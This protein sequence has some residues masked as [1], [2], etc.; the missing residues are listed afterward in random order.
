M[1]QAMSTESSNADAFQGNDNTASNNVNAFPIT[2]I[3]STPPTP[4]A[5]VWETVEDYDWSAQATSTVLT[6]AGTATMGGKSI[7]NVT[8]SSTPTYTTQNVNGSGLVWDV[9]AG[10]AAGGGAVFRF[11]LIPADYNPGEQV[12]LEMLI[13]G[14]TWDFANANFF[15][16]IGA[17]GHY[18][19]VE[20]HG[21]QMQAVAGLTTVNHIARGFS[22]SGGARSVTIAAAQPISTNYLVQIWYDGTFCSRV[23]VVEGQTTFLSQPVVGAAAPFNAALDTGHTGCSTAAPQADLL[24]VFA[25]TLRCICGGGTEE[26]GFTLKR[27][28]I[29]RPTRM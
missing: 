14:A 21:L 10:F 1:E 18:S 13:T 6:G 24:G 19:Q 29:S 2:I 26:G 8:V 15:W 27:H 16:G 4:S 20:W 11:D 7:T 12:L 17:G 23:A 28:R 3:S 25:S 22:T 5:P 9:T